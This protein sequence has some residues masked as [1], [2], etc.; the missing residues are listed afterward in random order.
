MFLLLRS[1]SRSKQP[2]GRGTVPLPSQV[3]RA[4]ACPGHEVS[5][6]DGVHNYRYSVINDRP[7]LVEPRT[8][9]IVEVVD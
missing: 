6:E 2:S 8:H 4:E 9:R 7:V 1:R 3:F 5:R